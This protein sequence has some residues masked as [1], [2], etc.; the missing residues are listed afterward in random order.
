MVAGVPFAHGEARRP[1]R[2]ASSRDSDRIVC[3]HITK[4]P[5]AAL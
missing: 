1:A 5:S 2:L 4:V 3:S